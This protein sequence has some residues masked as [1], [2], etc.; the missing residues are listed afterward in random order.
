MFS[1][2]ESVLI[3]KTEFFECALKQ[4]IRAGIQIKENNTGRLKLAKL[5]GKVQS[6]IKMFPEIVCKV[7]S[8]DLDKIFSVSFKF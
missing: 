7:Y 3:S 6:K 8:E 2:I 4:D 5:F 1:Q